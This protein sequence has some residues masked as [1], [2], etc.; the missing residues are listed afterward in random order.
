VTSIKEIAKKIGVSPSTVSFVLNG[1]EKE[2]RISET[3]AKEIRKVARQLGYQ[4]NQVAFSLRTGKSK[5]IALIVD[6]ISGS[7]FS[8]LARTIE[9][10]AQNLGYR[11]IYGS[12][13][14]NLNKDEN[15][16]QVLHQYHVDGFLIIP[17]EGMEKDI[18]FLLA[19]KK[20]VVLLDSYFP[21]V[22][23]SYVM[24][25][26]YEGI[27]KGVEHLIN[28]GYK[29]IAFVCNDI[30]M[31]QM[32]ERKKAFIETLKKR[33]LPYKKQLLCVTKYNSE[34]EEITREIET[35]IKTTKPEA[36]MFAANYLGVCG[37]QAIKNL[38]LKIPAGIAVICFD[39]LD[40][41]NLFPPGITSLRQPIKE[42]AKAAFHLLMEE[43]H[44][45]TKKKKKQV[46]LK[47]EIII[48]HS[49]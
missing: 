1:K 26:N 47:A 3:R 14:A 36:V 23:T 21:G 42:I 28:K 6:T 22:P 37:L 40:I 38:R 17:S 35:F 11:V 18:S 16:I 43:M 46:R 34:K 24:V 44:S 12:T 5:I 4:R 32:E 49:S 48:R 9:Q 8:A 29:K 13:I 20:P 41:F 33:K 31:V 27:A 15:V 2:M 10:E 45:T 39:D 7:F 30:K 25:D 19:H